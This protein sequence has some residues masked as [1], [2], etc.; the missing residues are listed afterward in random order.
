MP[1]GYDAPILTDLLVTELFWDFYVIIAARKPIIDGDCTPRHGIG[2]SGLGQWG[3]GADCPFLWT[4]VT[5][6]YGFPRG[7][8]AAMMT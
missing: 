4:P 3:P 1:R 7:F 5:I 8:R 6:N 2:Q